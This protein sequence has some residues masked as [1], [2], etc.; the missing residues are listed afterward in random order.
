MERT[1]CKLR[2]EKYD[3]GGGECGGEES[4]EEGTKILDG[5]NSRMME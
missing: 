2:T 1:K 5:L 4:E 3:P